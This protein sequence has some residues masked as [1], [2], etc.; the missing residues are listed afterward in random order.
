MCISHSVGFNGVN[1]SCDV[2]LIQV[3]LNENLGRLK[4]FA[5]LVTDGRVGKHVLDMIGEFQRRVLKLQNPTLKIDPESLA[6]R[7]LR[8]DMTDGLTEGKLQG[9]MIHANGALITR[10]FRPLVMM[11]ANNQIHTPLRISHFLAQIGHESGQLRY[12]EELA[13][14]Q[15][16]EGRTKLGNT[17]PGDGP[18]FK[19]R[20]LIQLTGRAN[21]V[22]YGKA[23]NRDFVTGN[24]YKLLATDPNLAVDVAC[25]FWT[26]HHL[27]ES[28]D[29]DDLN[30]IT[31]KINGGYNGLADRASNLKRAKFLLPV[32]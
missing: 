32:C 20:G 17:H 28:A 5:P 7:E 13:S 4:P 22:A 18:R 25:W 9:I 24:N 14:G 19:G 26:T 15:A 8:A 3:L 21:Y 10:Y 12:T 1:H 31:H 6:L 27:N 16:Y 23:R 2:K 30:R 11:M 29:A